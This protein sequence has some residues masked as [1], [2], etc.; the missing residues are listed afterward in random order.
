M[1]SCQPSSYVADGSCDDKSKIPDAGQ[2][3]RDV[4]PSQTANPPRDIPG[5]SPFSSPDSST[6][7]IMGGGESMSSIGR[8]FSFLFLAAVALAQDT[9]TGAIRGSVTDAAGA[10]VGAASV[11][12]VNTATNFRYATTTDIAGRFA[13]ELLPPGDYTAR[14]ESL[15]MSPRP[16]LACMWTW[17]APPN[18][19]SNWRWPG[20]EKR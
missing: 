16:R 8:Y 12:L 1:R 11:V 15:G 7:R 14:T 5:K 3:A 20:P 6:I 19:C 17:A 18:W 9:S 4:C 10:R 2:L 13:F